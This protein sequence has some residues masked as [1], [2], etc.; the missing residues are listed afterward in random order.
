MVRVPAVDGRLWDGTGWKRQGRS[1]ESRWRGGA[2]CYFSHIKALQNAI[3]QNVFPCM[4]VEDDC[5]LSEPP[6][7][8]PGMVYLGGFIK[9]ENIH[10]L[11]AVMY[12]TVKDASDFL[13]F[14]ATHK[15]NSDS[16]ANMYRKANPD[17]VKTYSKGFIATQKQNYSDIEMCVLER[18]ADG[19]LLKTN[20]TTP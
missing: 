11:H 2:G 13:V 3:D 10:G 9:G 15:N 18:T 19:K 7:A 17:K 12:H 1:V 4:I 14:L 6:I 5:I 16:V 20:Q 8:E